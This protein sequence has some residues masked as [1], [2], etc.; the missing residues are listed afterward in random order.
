MINPSSNSNNR[1]ILLSL[2]VLFTFVLKAQKTESMLL[3]EIS[4]IEL[5]ETPYASWFMAG[6]D[7]Y[8]VDTEKIAALR[9]ALDSVEITVFMGTWCSDSRREV[10]RFYKIMKAIGYPQDSIRLIAVDREKSTPKNL[11]DGLHIKRV[12]TFIFYKRDEEGVEEKAELNLRNEEVGAPKEVG[13][14][15]EYPIESLESDMLKILSGKKYVHA[16]A[17]P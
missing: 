12:P 5:Q 16:Y 8:D 17:K 3:G 15:V 9:E 6:Q 1:S 7:E 13:R 2:L 10:P 14:I 11:E 4:P